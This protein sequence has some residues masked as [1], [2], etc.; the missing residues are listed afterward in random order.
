MHHVIARITAL[1]GRGGDMR[2]VLETLAD[3]TRKES[4]CIQYELLQ[5]DDKPELFNTF[6]R[7]QD[8]SAADAH[9]STPHVVAAF[10]QAGPLLAAPPDI[11]H[12]RA[13]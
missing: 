6:E 8:R 4:G 1:P 2:A 13:C 7:W 3:A 9:M 12:L 11:Q 10:A 5:A